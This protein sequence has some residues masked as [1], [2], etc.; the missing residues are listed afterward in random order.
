MAQCDDVIDEISVEKLCTKIKTYR[1]KRVSTNPILVVALH[2]DVPFNNPSYQY[3]FARQIAEQ[4]D[5]VI[6]IGML[7]PGYT[8]H[9]NRTSDGIRGQTV[10]DNLDAPRVRQIANAIR[11]L[12]VTYGA[13]KV[14]VAGHSGGAVITA[15]MIALYP[16][17]V[18]HAFLVSCP[19]NINAWRADMYRSTK[20]PVFDGDLESTSPID[21]VS[22]ISD[23]TRITMFVGKDDAITKPYLSHDYESALANAGK[24][25]EL[26]VI[27]GDHE[28]FLSSHVTTAVAEAVSDYNKVN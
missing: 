24:N 17:L 18:D 9:L 6:G 2:G 15:K 11:Q 4:S 14:V 13:S 26:R 7:R 16:S 27:E 12:K 8:D 25:A 5:N 1:S 20:Y 23:E 3:H 28:I 19:G 21:L 10:G 22:K